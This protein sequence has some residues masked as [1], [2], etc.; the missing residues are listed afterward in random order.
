MRGRSWS[1]RN[2]QDQERSE[3]TTRGA[4]ADAA[5]RAPLSVYRA[6]RRNSAS[7]QRVGVGAFELEFAFRLRTV[8]SRNGLSAGHREYT[9]RP[10]HRSAASGRSSVLPDGFEAKCRAFG[11]VSG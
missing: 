9:A 10:L 6:D 2:S 5:S 8:R 7:L 4:V 11:S 3:P 1:D